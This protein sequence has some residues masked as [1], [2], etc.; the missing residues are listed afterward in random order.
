M[1]ELEQ[2]EEEDI[3]VEVDPAWG[4]V[5]EN[6]KKEFITVGIA[7][8]ELVERVLQEKIS[9]FVF[10]PYVFLIGTDSCQNRKSN[11]KKNTT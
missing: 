2:K 4:L 5:A 3:H 7:Q 9:N 8:W 6:V 10:N 1:L 11:K